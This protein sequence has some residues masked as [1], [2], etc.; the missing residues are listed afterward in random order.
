[1]QLILLGNPS[2]TGKVNE[3]KRKE[4]QQ[5]RRTQKLN[6]GTRAKRAIWYVY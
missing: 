2:R 5:L 4:F 1:M 6:F 3:I